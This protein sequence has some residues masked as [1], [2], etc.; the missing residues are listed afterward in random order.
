MTRIKRDI[1]RA[2][3]RAYPGA[4]ITFEKGKKHDFVVVRLPDNRAARV[5]YAGSPSAP[6]IT[7]KNVVRDIR[8][9]FQA[10]LRHS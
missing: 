2:L 4:A 6:D 1:Q 8:S 7:V 3:W 5:S 9:L 10:P